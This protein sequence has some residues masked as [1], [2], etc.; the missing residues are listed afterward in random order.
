MEIVT[1]LFQLPAVWLLIIS[2]IVLYVVMKFVRSVIAAVLSLTFTIVSILR[3]YL[4][5][6]GKL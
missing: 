2:V 5:L 6:S 3:I 1:A 4:F